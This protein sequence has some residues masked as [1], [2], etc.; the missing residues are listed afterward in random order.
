ME[1]CATTNGGKFD[2]KIHVAFSWSEIVP[3][4]GSKREKSL[5]AVLAANRGYGFFVTREQIGHHSPPE[6]F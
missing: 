4:C 6:K 5:N 1:F 2:Q 3:N